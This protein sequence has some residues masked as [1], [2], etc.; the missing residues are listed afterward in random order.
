MEHNEKPQFSPSEFACLLREQLARLNLSPVELV[1]LMGYA[2]INKGCRRVKNWLGGRDVPSIGQ[3]QILSS[4]LGFPD[5]IWTA[6]IER[7]A[8][9][10]TLKLSL[11]HI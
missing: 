5:E 7:D 8:N 6:A 3:L 2:N 1:R 10:A 4:V 11:I 9:R